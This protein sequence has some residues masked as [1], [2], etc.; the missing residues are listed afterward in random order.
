MKNDEEIKIIKNSNFSKMF[1]AQKSLRTEF[2]LKN[3][4]LCSTQF[5]KSECFILINSKYIKKCIPSK[6]VIQNFDMCFSQSDRKNMNFEEGQKFDAKIVECPATATNIIVTI[7]DSKDKKIEGLELA[8]NYLRKTV[9]NPGFVSIVKSGLKMFCLNISEPMF[10]SDKTVI[11]FEDKKSLTVKNIDFTQVGV[12]GL[13]TQLEELTKRVFASRMLNKD[14]FKKLGIK[15]VK[16]VILHGPP[17]NGKTA[18]ARKMGELTGIKHIKVINGPELL[19]K[20]VGESEKNIRD[21][22]EEA[23][24]NPDEIYLLIFDEFDALAT[25]RSGKDA[26][27]DKVVGQLLTMMD[28]VQEDNNIIVFALTNKL[29]LIDP[30][31]LRPGRFSLHIHIPKPNE[32]ARYEILKI[33]SK[34][35]LN[36]DELR[37]L[38]FLTQDFSGAELEFCIT[39]AVQDCIGK[40][41]DFKDIQESTRAIQNIEVVFED[42]IR[43]IKSIKPVK[44]EFSSLIKKEIDPKVVEN[45]LEHM[46]PNSIIC[47][48]GTYKSGKT[49]TLC[50]IA[51]KILSQ[52]PMLVNAK[53]LIDMNDDQKKNYLLEVFSSGNPVLIDDVELLIE[54]SGG[55]YNKFVVHAIKV[56]INEC[57]NTVIF[58]TS[59]KYALKQLNLFN[60]VDFECNL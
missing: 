4:V 59:N 39:K 10:V 14:L 7:V 54:Y 13:E 24:S 11:E 1:S 28:G 60:F 46:K 45:I 6:E 43:S 22:F 16:G 34:N 27:N 35:M 32:S 57:D 58:T 47:I 55:V 41:I 5:S 53:K 25:V 31:I 40:F 3:I 2:A 26:N 56:G 9:I 19:S 21:C 37:K 42:F 33:H 50:T 38:A 51:S 12:G 15:H 52:K 23:R 29:N 18:L 48:S 8:E 49:S 44:D 36:T 17:G 20:Y 30:A